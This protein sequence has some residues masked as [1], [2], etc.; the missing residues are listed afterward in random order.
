MTDEPSFKLPEY[1][2]EEETIAIKRQIRE[3]HRLAREEVRKRL[4][5]L[6]LRRT[7]P[8][9][10]QEAIDALAEAIAAYNGELLLFQASEAERKV[11]RIAA[12]NA[13]DMLNY[14][15]FD[16]VRKE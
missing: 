15:G 8:M 12:E 9:P 1:F 10:D 5:A 11:Y 13:L 4:A 16:I 2:T 7:S 6:T 14:R 3:G